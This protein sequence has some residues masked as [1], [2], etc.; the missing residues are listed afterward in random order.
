[1]GEWLLDLHKKVLHRAH[2]KTST[3][4]TAR[5]GMPRPTLAT[6]AHVLWAAGSGQISAHLSMV[7]RRP[8][9]NMSATRPLPRRHLL[10]M[11][12]QT[13]VSHLCDSLRKNLLGDTS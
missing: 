11:G 7:R 12:L 9:T 13:E 4:H 2:Q 8:R 10:L 3:T 1:M 6:R 5:S